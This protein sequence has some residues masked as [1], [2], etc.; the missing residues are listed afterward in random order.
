M[1]SLNFYFKFLKQYIEN[2]KMENKR[3][4]TTQENLVEND[5]LDSYKERFFIEKFGNGQYQY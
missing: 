3:W 2:K 4:K 1:N 5:L